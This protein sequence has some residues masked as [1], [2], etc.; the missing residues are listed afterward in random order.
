MA[1]IQS[2]FSQLEEAVKTAD[3]SLDARFKLSTQI[4]SL[5]HSIATP[6]QIIQHYA[7]MHTEQVVVK[8]VADLDI[9][10]ILTESKS[11]L[12]VEEIAAKTGADALLLGT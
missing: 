2:L 9:F 7:Y 8:I 1:A 5:A 11:S 3:L 4:K 12:T 10:Q 6:R